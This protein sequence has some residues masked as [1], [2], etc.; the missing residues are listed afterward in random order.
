VLFDVIGK[1]PWRR[2]T[3]PRLWL[4]RSRFA[5]KQLQLKTALDILEEQKS[6]LQLYLTLWE[7]Y[8]KLA[9]P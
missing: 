5:A 8:V 9:D 6:T 2:C 4:K 1:E 3:H 7:R